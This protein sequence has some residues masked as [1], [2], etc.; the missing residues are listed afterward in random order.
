MMTHTLAEYQ[1]QLLAKKI[2][3][4]ELTQFFLDKMAQHNALNSFITVCAETAKAQA[5]HADEL[6]AQ[7]KAGPLTGLPFAHKDIF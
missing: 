4:L 3:S 2:S 1:K 5:I 7:G 6:R